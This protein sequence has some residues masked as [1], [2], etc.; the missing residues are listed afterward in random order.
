MA[1]ALG[2]A[3]AKGPEAFVEDLD[4]AL[5]AAFGQDLRDTLSSAYSEFAETFRQPGAVCRRGVGI[6][7]CAGRVRVRYAYTP[8]KGVGKAVAE[9][10]SA[11]GPTA[12]PAGKAPSKPGKPVWPGPR[13]TPAARRAVA[14]AGARL[15]S[16]A[17][18]GEVLA[19]GRGIE[20]SETSIRAIVSAAAARTLEAWLAGTLKVA[21]LVL[22]NAPLP[23]GAKP[24]GETLAILADGTGAPS[25]HADTD[26]IPGKDGGEASTREIKVGAIVRY[27]HVDRNGRPIVRRGDIWHVATGG[28]RAELQRLL[29]ALARRRGL[30]RIR[31]VQYMGD[32]AAWVQKIWEEAFAPA[33]V[34]RSLDIIHACGYLHTVLEALCDPG[35]LEADYRHFRR[36]LKTWG[37][38]SVLRGLAE[39]FGRGKI[40][41]LRGDAR[42]A[43]NYLDERKAMM[44]YRQLRRDGY[45]IGSGVIESACKMLVAA[46][47]KLAGMHWRLA[48][49]AAVALLRGTIRSNFLIAV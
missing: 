37:G 2:E 29:L 4:A 9:K 13:A 25:T 10:L 12:V 22:P 36:R 1:A 19:S 6:L 7:T 28:D 46:R 15:D 24:V 38:E 42:T 3:A 16:Y 41:A 32:G 34:R 33:G 39:R 27:T 43:W 31:R 23:K 20:V 11:R 45:F 26:G 44:D 49:A 17:E 48:N 18:A 30:G 8:G 47:C 35:R 14:E 40:D 5:M 21:R